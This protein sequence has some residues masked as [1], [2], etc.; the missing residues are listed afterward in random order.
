MLNTHIDF[1]FKLPFRKEPG[2]YPATQK[3]KSEWRN[4]ESIYS[5]TLSEIEGYFQGI[6]KSHDNLNVYN[7]F[8]YKNFREE[9]NIT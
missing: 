2:F 8:I 7:E 1:K 9:Y 6:D 5:Y 3:L 4:K